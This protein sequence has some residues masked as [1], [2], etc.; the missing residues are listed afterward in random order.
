MSPLPCHETKLFKP[1][2][3]FSTKAAAV[4]ALSGTNEGANAAAGPR[5]HPIWTRQGLTPPV[6]KQKVG[7]LSADVNGERGTADTEV[8][9]RLE[10]RIERE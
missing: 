6:I 7:I 5:E 10:D 2:F 4:P 1:S 8:K 9:E 3:P